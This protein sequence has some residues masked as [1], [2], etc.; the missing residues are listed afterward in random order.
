MSYL[1]DKTIKF[2]FSIMGPLTVG[3]HAYNGVR[4]L[5]IPI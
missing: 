1:M 4:K 5:Y 3:S 2:A